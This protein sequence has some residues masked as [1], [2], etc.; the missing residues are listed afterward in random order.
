M[1]DWD[2]FDYGD[3]GD[4]G[5]EGKDGDYPESGDEWGQDLQDF[6]IGFKDRERLGSSITGCWVEGTDGRPLKTQTPEGRFCLR[7]NAVSRNINDRCG[8]KLLSDDDIRF[9]LDKSPG[10][11]RVQYKNST[12]FVLGY[13]ATARAT[14]KITKESL[15]RIWICYEK[16]SG[17]VDRD[18]SIKKHDI[19]RYARLWKK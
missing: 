6:Q 16:T 7:V 10:V 5:D 14:R 9:L 2:E 8:G 13:L 3:Y 4:Y 18:E 11:H 12:A 17:G 1:S 15:N 19:I